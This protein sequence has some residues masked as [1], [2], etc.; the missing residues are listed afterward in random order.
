VVSAASGSIKSKVPK[1]MNP[2]NEST[3]IC[4]G[5]WRKDCGVVMAALI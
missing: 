5:E 4:A 3:I 2:A 1:K